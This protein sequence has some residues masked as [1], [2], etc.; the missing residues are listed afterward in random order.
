MTYV[1]PLSA[2]AMALT[3]SIMFSS[4]AIAGGVPAGTLIENKASATYRVGSQDL[5]ADSNTVV[6]RVDELLDVAVASQD[7]GPVSAGGA[8]TVL[9]FSITNTGNGPEAFN[10]AVK[11]NDPA[12]DFAPVLDGIAVDTNANGIYDAGVDQILGASAPTESL[13]PD[14]SLTVFVLIEVPAT[15]GNADTAIVNL[16]AEA[17]TGTGAPGR[18]FAGKGEGGGDAVAGATRANDDDAA[19]VVARSLAVAITKSATV[20]DPFGGSQPVPGAI[21]TYKLLTAVTG[22]GTIEVLDVADAIPDGT[23]YSSGS[24]TLDSAPL[25]DAA[26]GDVGT[27]SSAGIEVAIG[28]ASAGD[29]FNITFDVV[30]D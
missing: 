14:D 2:S 8:N 20:V 3:A 26:D 16:R 1:K 6:L 24:L 19:T 9:T 5:D 13:D 22:T 11:T 17:V 21:I 18:V 27:A 25:T 30:I 29:S 4:P 7:S 28:D 23:S 10:L 15:A 12:N